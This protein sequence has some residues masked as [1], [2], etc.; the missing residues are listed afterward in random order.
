M[1]VVLGM[2]SSRESAEF[3]LAFPVQNGLGHN[4]ACRVAGAEKQHVELLLH[5]LSGATVCCGLRGRDN[6]RLAANLSLRNSRPP[7]DAMTVVR[8]LARGEERLPRN[9]CRIIY[10]R[11]FRL[12]VAAGGLTFLE[13]FALCL[14]Q[15]TVY[16]LQLI[17]ALDLDAKVVEPWLLPPRRN[18]KV[19]ARVI[20]H[21]FGVVGL[22][23]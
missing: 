20:Q 19:H 3:P 6:L 21:P 7:F 12:G 5:G 23:H 10:P 9:T 1:D 13:D 16:L 18:G 14:M 4:R 8:A 15:A 2:A 11:F 17:R 22:H